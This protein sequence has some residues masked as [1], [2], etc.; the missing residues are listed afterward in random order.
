MIKEE[1]KEE[2]PYPNNNVN[3]GDGNEFDK[4]IKATGAKFTDISNSKDCTIVFLSQIYQEYIRVVKKTSNL[5]LR[6]QAPLF[7]MV[8]DL[9]N[10]M[11]RSLMNLPKYHKKLQ[12]YYQEEESCQHKH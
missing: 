1:I 6:Y 7:Q 5:D 8:E 3:S 12:V 10:I 9:K 4:I 2:E 11:F